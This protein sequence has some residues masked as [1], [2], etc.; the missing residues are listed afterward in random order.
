[1][2]GGRARRAPRAGR[3]PLRRGHPVGGSHRHVRIHDPSA[4]PVEQCASPAAG[5]G[6]GPPG[7]AERVCVP[8]RQAPQRRAGEPRKSGPAQVREN[9]GKTA[10]RSP[11][12]RRRGTEEELRGHRSRRHQLL[13]VGPQGRPLAPPPAVLHIPR[14]NHQH[15]RRGVSGVLQSPPDPKPHA[16]RGQHA[17][18]GAHHGSRRGRRTLQR[19]SGYPAHPHSSRAHPASCALHSQGSAKKRNRRTR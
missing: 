8:A 10:A 2:C 11:Q 17:G 12:G 13:C 1:M 9:K 6:P 7:R 3:P 15:L 16:H 14:C 5:P 18:P 19:R 4:R